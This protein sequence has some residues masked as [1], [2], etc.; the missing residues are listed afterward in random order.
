VM[1]DANAALTAGEHAVEADPTW[2][3]ALYRV[4]KALLALRRVDEAVQR[5]GDARKQHPASEE[6]RALQ[7]TEV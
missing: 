1:H 6:L 7:V 4:V 5:V 2:P 3:R